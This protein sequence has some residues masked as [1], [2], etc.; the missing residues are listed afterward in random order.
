[1]DVRVMSLL[2]E[3]VV[4]R[5]G[6][7]ARRL[8]HRFLAVPRL[9]EIRQLGFVPGCGVLR[10]RVR[11]AVRHLVEERL[12]VELRVGGGPGAL[13]PVVRRHRAGPGEDLGGLLGAE[14]VHELPCLVGV[15]GLRRDHVG[16]AVDDRRLLLALGQRGDVHPVLG[17]GV[18]AELGG[19][20]RTAPVHRELAGLE[21]L[22]RRGVRH[23]LQVRR[24]LLLDQVG[25]EAQALDRLRVGVAGLLAVRRDHIAAGLGDGVV[26][27]LLETRQFRAGGV[28]ALARVGQLR[29]GLL[30]VAP[31]PAGRRIGDLG[32]V[33]ERLVVPHTDRVHVL[34]QAV[35]LALV[36]VEVHQLLWVDGQVDLVLGD[37]VVQRADH[38]VGGVE[39]EIGAVHPEHVGGGAA[40]GGRL[41]LGP[42][43]GPGGQLDLDR[44]LG[45][46]AGELAAELLHGC[47]LRRVPHPVRQGGLSAGTTCV[48]AATARRTGGGGQHRPEYH[49]TPL[50]RPPHTVPSQRS[51]RPGGGQSAG[52]A[53][54][55]LIME[56]M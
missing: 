10:D 13:R 25:P 30:E 34:R 47:L 1:M 9:G 52:V 11:H 26:L 15:L 18:A 44:D 20:P 24:L 5:R 46:G 21:E 23:G 12:Q 27:V 17:V 40:G 28:L 36:G 55:G 37:A 41:E 33:E 43:V 45:V 22:E 51:A 42:V 8:V 32:R 49:R 14:E 31:G 7:L 4:H 16:E 38:A 2:G 35:V 50:S 6:Q 56:T 3:Q 48:R 29:G 39:L 53:K 19:V 54:L